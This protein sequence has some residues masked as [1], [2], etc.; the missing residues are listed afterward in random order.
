MGPP[1]LHDVRELLGL[2]GE[3]GGEVLE[4]GDQIAGHGGGGGDV[5]GGGEDVVGRL[6]GVDM[7]IGMHVTA[8][9]LGGERG[10]DLVGVH[11]GRGAGPGL[12]DIDGEV[13]VPVPARD[14][15]G[16]VLDRRG[17]VLVEHPQLGVHLRRGTLDARERLDVR[18]L[19]ALAGDGEVL[20]GPLR[21]GTPLGV[22]GDAYFT[23]GVVLDAV[24]AHTRYS[25]R[26]EAYVP[27][28]LPPFRVD[29]PQP[30]RRV[31]TRPFGSPGSTSGCVNRT[32]L[33]SDRA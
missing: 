13:L 33:S 15:L 21:L 5:D 1:G 18:P 3:G 17:D 14:L 2:A 29:R 26:G 11:V 19:D 24:F 32:G 25:D 4:R 23:H 28:P 7:I 9:P 30:V 27:A 6:R 16:G 22:G 20:H 10:Q 31:R 12:E 8:E